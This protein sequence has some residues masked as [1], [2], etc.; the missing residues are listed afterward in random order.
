MFH[1]SNV[2]AHVLRYQQGLLQEQAATAASSVREGEGAEW[3]EEEEEEEEDVKELIEWTHG[4][5]YDE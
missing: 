4:L 1:C 2:P 5:N 3:R